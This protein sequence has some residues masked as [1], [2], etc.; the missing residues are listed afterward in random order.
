MVVASAAALLPLVS[1]P[2]RLLASSIDLET[3][4]SIEPQTLADLLVDAGFTR[5]D[6][7]DEHGTFTI[8]GG[9]V[10]VFPAGAAEPVRLEFVGD[11]IESLRPF[12]P[13]NQR[14]TG[15]LDRVSIV[16]LRER[17]DDGEAL[18]VLAF[19]GRAG[20]MI[21]ASEVEAVVEQIERVHAQ[22]LHAVAQ[23]VAFGVGARQS[24]FVRIGADA[25]PAQRR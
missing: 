2:E 11:L 22:E 5:E 17:F 12:N 4:T 25:G 16:P 13:T 19:L 23:S 18:S 6:P 15:A 14:S 1:T 10:D 20:L 8:R 3:G 21:V 7:V 24:G 9:I